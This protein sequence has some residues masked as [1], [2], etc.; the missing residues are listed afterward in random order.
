[1]VQLTVRRNTKLIIAILLTMIAMVS[2]SLVMAQTPTAAVEI[3]G[4]VTAINT[5]SITVGTQNFDI[6]KA[7]IKAGVAVGE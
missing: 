7:E 5:S 2:Q 4:S 6:S 3:V 1:M